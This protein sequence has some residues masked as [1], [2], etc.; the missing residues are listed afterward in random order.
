[1]D[2]I[3]IEKK[4][5][6]CCLE[7][8]EVRM[9]RV[10]AHNK[11]KGIMVQYVATYEYCDQADEYFSSEELSA[12]NDIAMKN[13]Y[14]REVGLLT[15][16][17]I[18]AIRARYGIS[19]SDLATL[20]GWGAKTITRYESH[21]VQDSAHN[22][23]LTKLVEDP[24]WFL[25]LLKSAKNKLTPDSYEKY[26]ATAN[27]LFQNAQ[28]DYLRKS[29]YAQYAWY[30]KDPGCCGFTVLNLDKVVDVVN[31]LANSEVVKRLYKT[32]LFK[33]LWYVDALAFK[34]TRKSMTGLI[35]QALPMGAVPVAG[36]ILIQLKGIHYEE[37]DFNDNIGCLFVGN[38][39]TQYPTL[40]DNDM[41]ILNTVINRFGGVTKT[42][43]VAYMHKERAYVE[44]AARDVIQYKYALDLSID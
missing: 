21:Q 37:V 10:A 8:H 44:T 42:D 15:T 34:R 19:Q 41:D 13:A 26:L 22:A 23:I 6:M 27:A 5:C 31:Y 11:F 32:K 20:L 29:I 12:A 9:V 18:C 3:K 7:E 14:R 36:D 40:T 39:L 24:E 28:D 35:Y 38:G 33:L 2:T 16:E 17:E 25:S 43:I 4:L 30:E 1:M